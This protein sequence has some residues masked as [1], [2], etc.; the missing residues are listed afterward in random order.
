MLSPGRGLTDEWQGLETRGTTTDQNLPLGKILAAPHCRHSELE[1]FNRSS[2]NL[3]KLLISLLLATLCLINQAVLAK[4]NGS[5]WVLKQKLQDMGTQTVYVGDDAVKIESS[6][7]GCCVLAKAPDW[8]VYC[9]RPVEKKL[10]VGPL[11]AFTGLLITNPFSF[12]SYTPMGVS[13][14]GVINYAGVNCVQFRPPN[15]KEW[16]LFA[17]DEIKTNKKAC[18]VINR[19]YYMPNT[20]QVPL[21]KKV[22]MVGTKRKLNNEWLSVDVGLDLRNQPRM[23]LET[24]SAKKV[25][26]HS[27]DF[28]IPQNLVKVR[29]AKEIS[30]SK[31]HRE[32][33]GDIVNDLGFASEF[34]NSGKAKP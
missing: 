21:C 32:Q 11:E 1:I 23:I 27:T 9:Y 26:Y 25:P 17:S 30:M 28:D 20:G 18:E 8:Q 2:A 14:A 13:R 15:A 31:T 33:L 4:T 34:V 19:Y 24:V 6:E 22:E 16:V 10:W 5:E 12:P 7:L 29:D 3:T